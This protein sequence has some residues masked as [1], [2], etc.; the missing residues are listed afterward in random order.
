M[1]EQPI[2]A[3]VFFEGDGSGRVIL[4]SSKRIIGTEAVTVDIK[5]RE[6]DRALSCLA[7][8][9]SSSL[10]SVSSVECF[11]ISEDGE[12]PLHWQDNIENTRWWDLLRPFTAVKNLY[13]SKILAPRI[14]PALRELFRESTP[15]VLPKLQNIFLENFQPSEP[16]ETAIW[17]FVSARHVDGHP[18]AVAHWD[19]E[20]DT[21]KEDNF[22]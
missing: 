11:Y 9:C 15:D 5:C 3:H 20:L 4:P 6:L 22:W 19:R 12:A 21:W 16:A 10:P 8:I 14:A 18:I 1:F 17:Q 2:E 13:L 7:Q